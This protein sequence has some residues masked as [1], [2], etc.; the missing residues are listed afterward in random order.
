MKNL[1]QYVDTFKLPEFEYE[2]VRGQGYFYFSHKW[3]APDSTP[4]PPPS[5]YTCYLHQATL[6]QWKKMIDGSIED[7]KQER[8]S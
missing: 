4:E 1:N 5:I 3:T 8:E 7:W 2:L 6:E